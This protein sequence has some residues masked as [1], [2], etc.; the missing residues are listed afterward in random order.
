MSDKLGLR[1]RILIDFFGWVTGMRLLNPP[2]FSFP[3][4]KR[5]TTGAMLPIENKG[6][7]HICTSL[8]DA[9][10]TIH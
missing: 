4:E 2:K 9:G 6:S 10:P 8:V 3:R 5:R 7:P 1:D